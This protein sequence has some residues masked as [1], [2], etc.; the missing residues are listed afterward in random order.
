MHKI[1]VGVSNGAH[2]HH[3]PMMSN[4]LCKPLSVSVSCL[5]LT[6]FLCF[7]DRFVFCT[8]FNCFWVILFLLC[9]YIFFFYAYIS[10]IMKSGTFF[11]GGSR[12]MEVSDYRILI[13][14]SHKTNIQDSAITWVLAFSFGQNVPLF[15]G[16][17]FWKRGPFC[18]SPPPPKKRP[19]IPPLP[20]P[21]LLQNGPR[22]PKFL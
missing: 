15:L 21:D 12:Q 7:S 20:L 1:F 8:F 5:S 14:K 10:I 18:T 4:L 16:P 17:L 19:M 13:Y 2:K 6:S 9:I 3:C 11:L 22:S